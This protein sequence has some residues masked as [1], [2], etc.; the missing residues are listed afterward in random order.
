MATCLQAARTASGHPLQE[1][2]FYHRFFSRISLGHHFVPGFGGYA[3]T[4]GADQQQGEAMALMQVPMPILMVHG[5]D[6]L[7][8]RP[9]YLTWHMW[10]E[11]AMNNTV[12]RHPGFAS[13]T[14]PGDHDAVGKLFAN[15][16]FHELSNPQIDGF[17]RAM[18]S[19]GSA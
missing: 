6:D 4:R 16:A 5:L 11:L 9:K 12:A 3:E 17:W 14:V 13:F 2:D 15:L 8:C 10:F 1:E 19:A 18:L 7:L